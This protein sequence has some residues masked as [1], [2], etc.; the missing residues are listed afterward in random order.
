VQALLSDP[1]FGDQTAA[2]THRG[3]HRLDRI[4]DHGAA[5]A[6][7]RQVGQRGASA[8]VTSGWAFRGWR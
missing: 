5:L 4:L 7:P 2:I 3:S 1:A 8:A 6:L